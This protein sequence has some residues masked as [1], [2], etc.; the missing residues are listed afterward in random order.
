MRL[1]DETRV[2]R[3][4]ASLTNRDY[5]LIGWLYDH[6]VLTTDQIAAALFSSLDVTQR[7][8]LRLLDLGLVNRFRPQRWE[9]GSYPYHYVLDQLGTELEAAQRGVPPPRRDQARR[10][11][12]HLTTRA[13][14]PH[15][16]GTNQFFIDLAAHERTHPGTRLARW[17]PAAAFHDRGAFYH[18]G[19]HADLMLRQMPRPDGHGI[20][21]EDG[22]EVAFF[23]EFDLANETLDDLAEKVAAYGLLGSLTRWRWPVLF[24]LPTALREL[25]LHRHL[26]ATFAA[27][28]LN[29]YIATTA[30]DLRAET[31]LSPAGAVWWL[32][33][34]DS[35]RRLRLIDLPC[36]T[37]R[38]HAVTE[39]P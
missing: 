11:R 38:P 8:L 27:T 31:G 16:L 22:R 17:R 21:A 37:P 2:L 23:L 25:H 9:G 35:G 12:V 32:Y 20:W 15:L 34:H 18:Q 13:N 19:D 26:A 10:R 24:H 28:P 29:A 1:S 3:A 4:Q 7:R 30:A 33:G 6:G 5:R 14:L 36:L 39:P